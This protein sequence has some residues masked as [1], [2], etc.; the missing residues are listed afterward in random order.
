MNVKKMAVAGMLTALAVVCSAFSIPVGASRCMPV[1]HMVNVL[2]GVLLGPAYAV[3]VAFATSLIRLFLSTGTLLAFPGSMLGALCCGLLYRA[4]KRIS[5]AC[6]GEVFGTGI[7]GALAAYPI[8][9]FILSKEAALFGFV[10]PFLLSSFGGALLSLLI[11]GAMQKAGLL[12]KFERSI[13]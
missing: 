10:G 8:A 3:G 4:C 1:Q 11:L 5:L 2:G 7:L 13:A 9:A 6:I 12:Q